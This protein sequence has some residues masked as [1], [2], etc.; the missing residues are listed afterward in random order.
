MKGSISEF[1]LGVLRA[2]MLDAARSK[3]RRGELRLSVPFGYIWH[4]E[5]GLGLDPDLRLQDVIRSVFARLSAMAGWSPSKRVPG[6]RFRRRMRSL[7][8]LAALTRA[9]LV[10][11]A[12]PTARTAHISVTLKATSSWCTGRGLTRLDHRAS[13]LTEPLD[14]QIRSP[15][16][17]LVSP[18]SV[19]PAAFAAGIRSGAAQ[20]GG[21]SS[22]QDRTINKTAGVTRQGLASVHRARM[23]SAWPAA[24]ASFYDQGH[25]RRSYRPVILNSVLRRFLSLRRIRACDGLGTCRQSRRFCHKTPPRPRHRWR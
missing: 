13:P 21:T 12:I 24:V 15:R 3:A 22:S 6:L 19:A 9:L 5:A 1:E 14:F 17:E 16:A 8:P 11:E 2:R 20:L 10:R 7:W 25:R 4:R 23:M 18:N